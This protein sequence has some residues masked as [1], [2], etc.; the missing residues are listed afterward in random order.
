MVATFRSQ[1]STFKKLAPPYDPRAGGGYLAVTVGMTQR[2]KTVICLLPE[3]SYQ[4]LESL[5]KALKPDFVAEGLA[6]GQFH[7]DC[8]FPPIHNSSSKLPILQ[9]PMSIIAV[10]YLIEHDRLF[11][12]P[13]DLPVWT[14][15]KKF[16]PN[17]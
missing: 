13:G 8:P 10:R 2:L 1:I 17:H 12:D 9:A 6:I 4:K 15:H 11:N 7:Y 5:Q 16:F 3:I 14:E